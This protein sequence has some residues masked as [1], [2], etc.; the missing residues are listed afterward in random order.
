METEPKKKGRGRPPK[1]IKDGEVTPKKSKA[2]KR[3]RP[4]TDEEPALMGHVE[5]EQDYY[6]DSEDFNDEDD[7][8]PTSKK[9]KNGDGDWKAAKSPKKSV[10]GG[11]SGRGRGRPKGSSNKPTVK[12]EGGPKRGRGRPKGSAGGVGRGKPKK[13][14]EKKSAPKKAKAKIQDFSDV[15]SDE[16]QEVPESLDEGS[17]DEDLD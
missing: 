16:I 10:R 4:K 14:V 9:S 5:P 7:Y 8:A 12:S 17:E 13:A 3:G 2:T 11:S 1:A 6:Y 15:E